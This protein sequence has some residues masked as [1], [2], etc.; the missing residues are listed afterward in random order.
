MLEEEI[1]MTGVLT[2]TRGIKTLFKKPEGYKVTH[3]SRWPFGFRIILV[4]E[5]S[6][7]DG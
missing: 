5:K 4:K 6:K 2:G 3:V 7:K 1:I